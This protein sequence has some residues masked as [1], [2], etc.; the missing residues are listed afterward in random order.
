MSNLPSILFSCSCSVLTDIGSF[1]GKSTGKGALS[2]WTHNLDTLELLPSYNSSFYTGPALK[3]GAGVQGANAASFASKHGYRL[4]IGSCPSVGLAGGYAQGGGHSFLSGLYG[5]A[6]DNVLEWEVVTPDGRHLV[7]TPNQNTDLYFALSGGGGGTYAVV[8]SM[9]MRVFKDGPIGGVSFSF[10]SFAAGGD[11]NFW[12][13]IE[14]FH[15][16][17]QPLVDNGGIS[18]QYLMSKKTFSVLGMMAPNRT[19]SE[20]VTL[21]DPMMLDLK[22]YYLTPES[23]GLRRLDTGTFYQ[24]YTL[25]IGALLD[26]T[27]TSGIVSGRMI[28]RENMAVER[29]EIMEAFRKATH[30]EHIQLYGIAFNGE[31][32]KIVPPVARNSVQ[33]A[34]RRVLTTFVIEGLW[35]WYVSWDEMLR[36]QAEIYDVITPAMVAATPDSGTYLNE[37]SFQEAHWQDEFYGPNY[38]ELKRIKDKY[39]PDGILYGVTAVGSEHWAPDQE[40]RLCKTSPKHQDED[41]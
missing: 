4:V 36:R 37:A 3:M 5:L 13:A 34:W 39:D 16:H 28:S 12:G 22:K 9:T 6:A 11:E 21:L 33:P 32:G 24:Y 15:A 20:L 10:S 41:L 19:S 35:D 7:A 1:L 14:V 18:A 40:G 38:A 2:L 8:V 26:F 23:M 27:P 29:M 25:S 17:L 31:V 30:N